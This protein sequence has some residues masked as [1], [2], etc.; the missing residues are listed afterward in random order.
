MKTK[1]LSFCF[2]LAG[3]FTAMAQSTIVGT[4]IRVAQKENGKY[5]GWTTDWIELSGD[6]RPTVQITEDTITDA[7]STHY[8]YYIKFTFQGETTEGTY[9]YDPERSTKIRKEW[10]KKVVNCYVDDEGD[11]MYVEDTSLQE[12]AKDQNA[13]AKYDGSA[14]QFLNKDMNVAFK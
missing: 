5:V 14:I 3:L 4:Q 7:A 8:I 6:D 2:A 10:N 1:L 12:L 9:V 11:Y 13:W